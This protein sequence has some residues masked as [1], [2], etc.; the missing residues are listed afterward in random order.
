MTSDIKKTPEKSPPR[1]SLKLEE[2][3]VMEADKE[4]AINPEASTNKRTIELATDQSIAARNLLYNP[5]ASSLAVISKCATGINAV[6]HRLE[7]T[8]DAQGDL[9]KDKILISMCTRLMADGGTGRIPRFNTRLADLVN[10][11]NLNPK[12]DNNYAASVQ[13]LAQECRDN[14][15][16]ITTTAVK[17]GPEGALSR[18]GILAFMGDL[19]GIEK[20]ETGFG[21]AYKGPLC[22]PK[23]IYMTYVAGLCDAQRTL[24]NQ[25]I[26]A[27]HDEIVPFEIT[28]EESRKNTS[29]KG[30]SLSAPVHTAG[31]KIQRAPLSFK[32]EERKGL[33]NTGDMAEEK[34]KTV[35]SEHHKSLVD[36]A[37]PSYLV[38]KEVVEDV[39]EPVTGHISGTF[40]EMATNM[41]LF[42]GTPPDTITRETPSGAGAANSDQTVSIAALAAAGLISTGFHSAVEIYQ[43]MSTFTTHATQESIGPKA[44]EMMNKHVRALRAYADE[45]EKFVGDR[46][47]K[48][49]HDRYT[50]DNIELNLSREELLNKA[51][52]L[53]NAATKSVDMISMLQGGGGSIA[54]LEVSR[55]MANQSSYPKIPFKLYSVQT[56]LDELGLRTH[57]PELEKARTLAK[58]PASKEQQINLKLAISDAECAADHRDLLHQAVVQADLK[59]QRAEAVF[60]Q[61]Q[62]NLDLATESTTVAQRLGWGEKLS[63]PEE[64]L[65]ARQSMNS[66]E[67]TRK[68]AFR[69]KETA[70]SEL[71]ILKLE[72]NSAKKEA[73]AAKKEGIAQ[74]AETTATEQEQIAQQ[75]EQKAVMTEQTL[76]LQTQK[77]DVALKIGWNTESVLPK[78]ALN[79]QQNIDALEESRR[80]AFKEN[81]VAKKE[82]MIAR[83][84]A[85]N[86]KNLA[87]NLR[88]EATQ[89]KEE[90]AEA[91]K[92]VIT[93]KSDTI[94]MMEKCKITKQIVKDI[95]E[96][97]ACKPANGPAPKP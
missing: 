82:A 68:Q 49:E 70:K 64:A 89:A 9:K 57:T 6:M 31:K 74:I 94:N 75:A 91:T 40:G 80:Q 67:N 54:T 78:A 35:F 20:H 50:L 65:Q 83:K 32:V 22:D 28:L 88:L 42:C 56:Q 95:K 15:A 34:L 69:E 58:L 33:L 52:S 12:P 11:Q 66:L 2:G 23:D 39:T 44:V 97:T 86:A 4:L 84:T 90:A 24:T 73:A 87:A 27:S 62:K 18:Q 45:L 46:P 81:V 16:K 60:L 17:P 51:E 13:S 61:K 47:K 76:S 36:T 19:G 96:N 59:V 79:S 48:W 92:Q 53:E 29:I 41:N 26:P 5:N 63:S 93:A 55:V 72:A 7:H 77:T 25:K 30:G 10:M 1:S 43:P 71:A 37:W 14:M 38:S 21:S 3:V 85:N 8:D